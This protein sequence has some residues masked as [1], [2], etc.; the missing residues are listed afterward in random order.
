MG[1]LILFKQIV[2]SSEIIPNQIINKF[3]FIPENVKKGPEDAERVR[4][5]AEREGRRTRRRR[6][7]EKNNFNESH[8]DG[9]SSDDEVADND[10]LQYKNQF[11]HIQIEAGILMEDASEEFSQCTDILD[12]F[13][14]WRDG[15]MDSYREGRNLNFDQT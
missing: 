4:R 14:S 7:R 1:S 13:Q 8:Y 9:M 6:T 10:A 5:A 3:P 11:Y 15:E 12:K 2:Y